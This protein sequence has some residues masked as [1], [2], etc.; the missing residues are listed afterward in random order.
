M[1]EVV[2]LGKLCKYRS[3]TEEMVSGCGEFK[4]PK[5]LRM[6][7]C[8]GCLRPSLRIRGVGQG[9]RKPG[10]LGRPKDAASWQHQCR[11]LRL[12]APGRKVR[13]LNSQP[14]PDQAGVVHE[15]RRVGSF[16]FPRADVRGGVG[17]CRTQRAKA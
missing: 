14:T 9:P 3:L 5:S 4:Q 12:Y 1:V 16:L 7:R 10:V 13:V 2:W 17:M 11:L 8:V 6:M 15:G